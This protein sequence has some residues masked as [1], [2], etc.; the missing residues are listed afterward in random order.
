[1]RIA[2][3]S[4][5]QG[6]RFAIV[7]E[8]D[9]YHVLAD[10]PIYAG[11]KPTGQVVA[12]ADANLVS[13]MIPRSKV[14]GLGGTYNVGDAKVDTSQLPVT[15]LKPNTSVIGPNVPITYPTWAGEVFHEPELAVI[16][17][18]MAKD[19]PVGKVSEVVF[20]YTA[21]DDVTDTLTKETD[22]QWTRAK[23]FDTACPL[24]PVIETELDLSNLSIAISI[25]GEEK[26]RSST[27]NLAYSV[28]ELVS[29]CS[30][31]FTLLPGDV[32]L[33]GTPVDAVPAVPGD[34]VVVSVEGIGELRN[35]VVAEE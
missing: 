13:P 18:R 23:G 1:M 21:A 20:G 24:G 12:G 7:D 22:L 31:M 32:I 5:P 35:P 10:D 17:S 19:V 29:I 9:N 30:K 25:N 28:A 15:F 3:I 2:R 11:I 6:P 16:I 34:E 14:I 4:L 33:T 26:G 8:D 27:A